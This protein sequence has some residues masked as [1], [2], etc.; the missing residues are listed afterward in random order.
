MLSSEE[1]GVSDL[2]VL[3]CAVRLTVLALAD[4][5]AVA[6][7][8]GWIP[9]SKDRKG[10]RQT[11]RRAS[12]KHK[13]FGKESEAHIVIILFIFF[14]LWNI[15]TYCG[16]PDKLL[17]LISKILTKHILTENITTTYI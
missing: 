11:L 3:A 8:L 15:M 10:W 4:L 16:Q 9:S 1:C 5:A 13:E 6:M 17:R 14:F 2:I 12:R 7:A